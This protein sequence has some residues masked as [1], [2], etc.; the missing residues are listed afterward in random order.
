MEK[1]KEQL[2]AG[3]SENKNLVKVATIDQFKIKK[4]T[5]NNYDFVF[6]D[7]S[8]FQKSHGF[9]LDGILGF[10]FLK[11]NLISFDFRRSKL[12]FWEEKVEEV[13][14]EEKVERVVM[15]E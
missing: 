5:F 13:G 6:M 9:P 8:S 7:L 1:G 4:Q 3:V 10:P 11:E 15:R 14:R 2:M 12:N